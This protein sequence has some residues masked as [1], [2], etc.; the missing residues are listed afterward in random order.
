MKINIVL[1]FLS[2]VILISCIEEVDP[3]GLK[4][5]DEMVV[6]NGYLS[7]SDPVV[8]IEVSRTKPVIRKSNDYDDKSKYIIKN[9]TVI[10]SD[11]DGNTIS[12]PYDD[13]ALSYGVPAADFPIVGGETYHLRVDVGDKTYTSTCTVPAKKVEDIG[14]KILRK[15]DFETELVVNFKDITGG[16]NF[17]RI[18]AD[19][20]VDQSAWSAYF[21]LQGFQTD[22]ASDGVSLSARAELWASSLQPGDQIIVKIADVD[23]VLYRYQYASFNYYGDDPF[24]EAVVFPSNIEGGLGIFA[25]YQLTEK[26]FTIN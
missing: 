16:K 3:K 26:T 6:I 4:G 12:L 11:D 18:G 19:V 24:S 21:D 22:A 25:G 23:E 13:I 2:V 9:A 5:A 8:S 1:L 14:Y 7:P 10:L 15:S 17:Y 20:I